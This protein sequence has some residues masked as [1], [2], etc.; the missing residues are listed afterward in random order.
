MGA[1]PDGITEDGECIVEVK[2]PTT[3]K[4]NFRKYIKEDGSVAAKHLAQVQMLMHVTCKKRETRGRRCEGRCLWY[5]GRCLGC[6]R[7]G[8]RFEGRKVCGCEGGCGSCEGRVS[9]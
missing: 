9:R 2:C 4:K 5:E 8:R 7:R 6:E 1:S 3:L